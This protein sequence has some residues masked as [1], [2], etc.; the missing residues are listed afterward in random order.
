M[1]KASK[2]E[3]SLIRGSIEIVLTHPK[4]R[5]N[6]DITANE[7]KKSLANG[8]FLLIDVRQPDEFSEWNIPG[9]IN[10]PLGELAEHDIK[11]INP[12]NKEVVTICSH[13]NRSRIAKQILSVRGFKARSLIGGMTAW[14]V[15][16]EFGEYRFEVDQNVVNL[17]QMRRIGKGCISYVIASNGE[18]IAIDPVFPLEGYLKVAG[19]LN[20]KIKAVYDTHLHADH[21]SAA[22]ALARKSGAK[23]HLSSHE[24]YGFKRDMLHDGDTHKLGAVELKVMHTPGHTAGSFSFLV[25]NKV[26]ITG[27]MLFVNGVGRPDLRDKASEFAGML[28]DTLHT[29]ILSLPHDVLIYPAHFDTT[30]KSEDLVTATIGEIRRRST[31]LALNKQEFVKQMVSTVILPPPNHREIIEINRVD[32][33]VPPE[34]EIY[35]LEMGPNRCSITGD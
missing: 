3:T 15:A 8:K 14:S 25:G 20:A 4:E 17:V 10:V 30:G 35:E 31:L 7:L 16:S 33:P 21:V 29:K 6:P 23:L 1:S 26:L 32:N 11:Q 5:P 28:H 13:G 27:D 12:A 22:R 18:A 2:R 9:S 24:E 34:S 19:D